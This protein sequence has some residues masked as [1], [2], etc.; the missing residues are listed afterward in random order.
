MVSMKDMVNC[1]EYYMAYSS[2][3]SIMKDFFGYLV[4]P[5]GSLSLLKQVHLLRGKN[6][7]LNIFLVATPPSKYPEVAAAIKRA[8]DIFAQV[9]FGIARILYYDISAAVS[10][11]RQNLNNDAEA[12]ALTHEWSVRDP[13]SGIDVFF[14][15][16]WGGTSTLGLSPRPGPCDKDDSCIMTGVVILL[17]DLIG[18]ITGETLAHELG[19][20]LG[21]PHVID[22][23]VC[24][25]L[26]NDD[27]W[28]IDMSE[29]EACWALQTPDY[30]SRLMFPST[31]DGKNIT[32]TG[33]EANTMRGH[34]ST[35]GG[36]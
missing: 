24:S 32:M 5:K 6:I 30:T 11:G 33:D 22:V 34:C 25:G 19:H 14:V 17:A 28:W 27:N 15:L 2:N 8:R 3:I 31:A 23:T 18:M 10:K 21:L 1:L 20:F 16:S 12:K 9:D 35:R 4:P 29:E 7:H 26:I 36:C 13:P